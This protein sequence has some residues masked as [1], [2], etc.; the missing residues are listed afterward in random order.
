[1]STF[2]VIMN[3]CPFL[4]EVILKKIE[5]ETAPLKNELEK[6]KCIVYGANT[7]PEKNDKE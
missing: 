2:D 4:K 7:L 1:M 3:N 5:E 6:L